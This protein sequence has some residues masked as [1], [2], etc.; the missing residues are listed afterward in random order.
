MAIVPSRKPRIQELLAR[1]GSER[2]AERDSAVAQLTL[3]GSRAVEPLLLALAGSPPP[4]RRAA[5]EVLDRLRDPRA[6]SEVLALVEDRD[7][8]TAL[9]A[10][11][12]AE[13][14]PESRTARTLAKAL[15]AGPPERRRAAARS[16]ARIHGAGVVEAIDPLLDVLLDE[17]EDE[18]EGLRL[19]VL[20]DLLAL[21]PPLSAR[22]L[23]PV[24]KRLAGSHDAALAARAEAQMRRRGRR[25]GDSLRD[26]LERIGDPALAPE[27]AEGLATAL[28][29]LGGADVEALHK[30]LDRARRPL[31]VRVL[32]EA[33]AHVGT[34]ASIPVLQR[35]L[36]RLGFEGAGALPEDEAAPR[37][38]AKAH[39][40]VALAARDSRIALFDLRQMLGA[41]PLRA[42][43]LLLR[44]AGLIGEGSLV[45]ALVR[46]AAERPDRFDDCGRAF[47]AIVRRER[48]RRT[49]LAIRAVR[50]Q[51]RATLEA[52][53]IRSRRT[54]S[55]LR[56]SRR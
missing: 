39:V 42:L 28:A 5:L 30:A 47:A 50:A 1:L 9:H 13:A 6:L 53:W 46:I 35:A 26:A 43:P 56:R 19:A 25:G 52:L 12:V 36:E 38:L 10:V 48:L 44:A 24:L 55:G 4:F 34:T 33:L 54:P 11:G 14:Y 20:D 8:E 15:L 51:D 45:P 3:L 40:H 17:D 18:D 49:S 22:T 29:R 37:A 7:P 23:P 31:D 27:E 16:L 21:D 41:R 32:A 2:A